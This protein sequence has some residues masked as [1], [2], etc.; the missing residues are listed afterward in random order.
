MNDYMLCRLS[1]LTYV[2]RMNVEIK[3]REQRILELIEF[4][5]SPGWN[6]FTI[7]PLGRR[8]LKQGFTQALVY[9]LMIILQILNLV[10]F[11]LWPLCILLRLPIIL[12]LMIFF[13]STKLIFFKQQWN[14]LEYT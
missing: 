13:S 14:I 10:L 12:M 8:T 11:A 5:D 9:S 4:Y 3:S 6:P 7:Y 1:A 2:P